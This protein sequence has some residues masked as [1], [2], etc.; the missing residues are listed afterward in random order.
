[1]ATP[2]LRIRIHAVYQFE[3]VNAYNEPVTTYY[4]SPPSAIAGGKS[5]NYLEEGLGGLIANG[6]LAYADPVRFSEDPEEDAQI[7]QQYGLSTDIPGMLVLN[8]DPWGNLGGPGIAGKMDIDMQAIASGQGLGAWSA[9][10]AWGTATEFIG[11]SFGPAGV[12]GLQWGEVNGIYRGWNNWNL[13]T[14]PGSPMWEEPGTVV[15]FVSNGI[16]AESVVKLGPVENPTYVIHQYRPSQVSP[17]LYDAIVTIVSSTSGYYSRTMNWGGRYASLEGLGDIVGGMATH[18]YVNG[19]E[20]GGG[21][22]GV[23]DMEVYGDQEHA[24]T[25]TVEYSG[26]AYGQTQFALLVG[27]AETYGDLKH[28]FLAS[29]AWVTAIAGSE[30]TLSACS[31]Q[32]HG[33]A[34]TIAGI[35]LA[36]PLKNRSSPFNGVVHNSTNE[37]VWI[38][39]D[40]QGWA[41]LGPGAR[42]NSW[43]EDWDYVYVPSSGK[44]YAVWIRRVY[45]ERA[46]DGSVHVVYYG[47]DESTHHVPPLPPGAAPP[48]P[49]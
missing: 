19:V 27:M 47:P 38:W 35:A 11:M 39:N 46:F 18:G 30:M 29:G 4:Y 25:L 22:G 41:Q 33:L 8:V 3:G 44:Y 42:T 12:E 40:Q 48:G 20:L 32:T 9:G 23:L 28:A 36:E 15:S 49:P 45:V 17:Y 34:G 16:N 1:M 21:T 7:R 10:A 13:S 31:Q 24:T 14:G 6:S 2:A 26:S 37:V 5:A 43:G